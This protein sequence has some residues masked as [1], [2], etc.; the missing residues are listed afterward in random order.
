MRVSEIDTTAV[1]L[2]CQART[3]CLKNG[4]T[5]ILCSLESR[6]KIAKFLRT[7]KLYDVFGADDI[8]PS[9]DDG[10]AHVEDH[11]LNREFGP[12]RYERKLA[13][14]EV[15]VLKAIG[16]DH[17][18][19]LLPRLVQ[20]TFRDGEQVFPQGS[21]ADAI[22]FILQGQVSIELK[23]GGGKRLKFGVLCPGAVFGEMAVLYL[24]P[25]SAGIVAAGDVVCLMLRVKNL[26]DLVR[27]Q[28]ASSHALM[29]AIGLELSKRIRVS[30]R[31]VMEMK[32]SL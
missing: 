29:A 23:V 16:P 4:V 8:H 21:A 10:L 31:V 19:V 1:S 2:I 18:M 28:P 20:R 12:G 27:L 6:P 26:E 25:R 24:L 11:L 9:I 32:S 5:L 13:P 17:L 22:F 14:D 7:S 30:N 15:G 3:T